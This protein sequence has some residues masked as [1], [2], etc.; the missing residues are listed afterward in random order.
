VSAWLAVAFVGSVEMAVRFVRD[1]R[2][3]A[4]G[5][6]STSGSDTHDSGPEPQ[7]DTG[8]DDKSRDMKRA[9][10]NPRQRQKPPSASDKVRDILRCEPDLPK[11]DVAQLACVSVR[12]V[13]RVI[14]GT[15]KPT[16]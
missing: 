3:V 12:T 16:A 1:A 6:D 14:S 8:S 10:G 15:G 7:R 2:H 5:S 4:T 11:A 13:E 9:P